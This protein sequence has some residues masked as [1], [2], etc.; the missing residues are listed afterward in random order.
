MMV[1]TSAWIP[2]TEANQNFS[3]VARLV[4]EAGVA[5]ILKNDRPRY[6]LV[7]FDEYNEIQAMRENRRKKIESTA[8]RLIAENLE[9]F[10]E[11]AK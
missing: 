1:N 2:M 10:E 4:D 3:N 5:V 7:S 8:S 9:A 6:V 11:L